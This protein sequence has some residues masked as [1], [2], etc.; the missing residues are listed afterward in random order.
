MV[1]VSMVVFVL[2]TLE[3]C[4]AKVAKWKSQSLSLIVLAIRGLSK[5]SGP[6]RMFIFIL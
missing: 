6:L 1:C 4:E 5:P 2:V 3:K